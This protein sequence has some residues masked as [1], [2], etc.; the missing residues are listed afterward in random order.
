MSRN[1]SAGGTVSQPDGDVVVPAFPCSA[2]NPSSLPLRALPSRRHFSFSCSISFPLR[3]LFVPPP[4]ATAACPS[5]TASTSGTIM[6]LVRSAS[7]RTGE[8]IA[9]NRGG[10]RKGLPPHTAAARLSFPPP[11]RR[12]PFWRGVQ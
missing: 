12:R 2:G 6:G 10:R 3:G 11:P 1:T 8:Q 9:R 4:P 7:P 5:V